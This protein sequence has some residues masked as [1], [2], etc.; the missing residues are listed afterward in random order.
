MLVLN[1]LI[2]NTSIFDKRVT[3][4]NLINKISFIFHYL[5]LYIGFETKT[6]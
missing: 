3:F 4:L 5:H 2:F 1:W 6:T